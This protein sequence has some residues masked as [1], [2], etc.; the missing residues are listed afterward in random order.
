MPETLDELLE[1]LA[2]AEA[3]GRPVAVVGLGSNLLVADEGFR[4]LVV[5]LAGELASAEVGRRRAR[6]GRRC[7]ARG[8]PPPGARC[9]ARRDRVRLRHPRDRRRRRL[10]ERR[11]LRRRHRRSARAR[12]RRGARWRQLALAGGARPSLPELGAAARTGRRARRVP[13]GAATSLGDQGDGR[14]DAGAAEGGAADEQ[15]N[16]RQRL[17]EPRARAD[18]RADARGMRAARLPDR[19]CADLAEARELHRERRR[20]SLGRRRSRSSPRL[21]GAPW[22][23]SACSCIRRCSSSGRSRSRGCRPRARRGRPESQARARARSRREAAPASLRG[24]APRRRSSRRT[25]GGGRASACRSG[26]GRPTAGPRS[27]P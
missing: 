23:S 12:P 11:R 8:V 27:A 1:H 10:D 2:R 25:S 21:G 15:A 7:P 4:G 9:R 18:R 24:R 19:R 22:R 17:Q 6:R 16:L 5:K 13:A 3:E 26:T 14:R 20:G